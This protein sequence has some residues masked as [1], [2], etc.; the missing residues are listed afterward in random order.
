MD[1]PPEFHDPYRQDVRGRETHS[2]VAR[3]V[4]ILEA[5]GT[6]FALRCSVDA[7]RVNA[8]PEM[9]NFLVHEYHPTEVA[10]EP[11]MEQGRCVQQKIKAP[12]PTVFVRQAIKAA[13][14][15]RE[16]GVEVSLRNAQP[17]LLQSSHCALARDP[18]V[19]TCD[20]LISACCRIGTRQTTGAEDYIIGRI[21]L[22]DRAVII[23]EKRVAEMRMRH[24]NQLPGCK[25]CFAKWHC[26]GG[27][28]ILQKQV[29]YGQQDGYLCRITRDLTLW[30]ILDQLNAPDPIFEEYLASEHACQ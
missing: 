17:E 14:I 11:I 30:A 7:E 12:D 3:T 27:C 2:K 21:D 23:D 15:A 4:R 26:G 13:R 22:D 16:A 19:V 6:R 10:I 25:L 8:L 18:C 9:V 20:G 28:R 29:L 1:G 24:I 5:E